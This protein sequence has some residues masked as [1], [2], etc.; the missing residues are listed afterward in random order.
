[1]QFLKGF[2]VGA[3]ALG[4][5]IVARDYYSMSRNAFQEELEASLQEG[6][7]ELENAI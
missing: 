4:L 3:M 2:L 5:V 1:M 7:D 6:F